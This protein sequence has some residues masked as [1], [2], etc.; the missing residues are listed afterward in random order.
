[1][2][3]KLNKRGL[4]AE[5]ETRGQQPALRNG[6]PGVKFGTCSAVHPCS[7]LNEACTKRGWGTPAFDLV[8]EEG[9]AHN[10]A[11]LFKV[12]INGVEY[13][14]T[15]TGSSKKLAKAEVAK[16]CLDALGLLG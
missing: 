3:I 2:E 4:Q 15:V 12:K 9:T 11:F 10:K 5:G 8:K 14:P 16:W 13:R 6:V 1:M 7:A